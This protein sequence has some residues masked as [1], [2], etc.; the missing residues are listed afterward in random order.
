[1][2]TVLSPINRWTFA[3]GECPIGESLIGE[4]RES[5]NIIIDYSIIIFSSISICIS[6]GMFAFIVYH[7]VK[8]RN[9]PNRVALLLTGNMYLSILMSCII[10]LDEYVRVLPG[11]IYS[12]ISLNDG[13]YCQILAYLKVVSVSAIFYSNTLQ[14]IYRLCRIVFYTRQSLQSFQLYKIMIIIQWIICFLIILPNLLLGD[15]KYLIDDYHCQVE[16]TDIRNGLLDAGLA[17]LIPVSISTGCY[18]YTLRKIRRG[19]NSL[20]QTMTHIQQITTRRDIIVFFRICIL[21]GLLM[22]TFIPSAVILIIYCFAKYSPWWASQN[23]WLDFSLLITIVTLVLAL[24][25]P[26]VRNLWRR[27]THRHHKIV[28]VIIITN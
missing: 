15:F 8:T 23:L 24:V 7:L 3:I 14:A 22:V 10:L 13:I 17:Y 16:L 26:H 18:I 25:S 1:M 28:P 20:L 21:N 9:S 2:S 19:Q 4:I 6:T 5:L 27:N 11:H 12:L